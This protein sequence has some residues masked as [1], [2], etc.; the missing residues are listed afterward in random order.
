[1]LINT[2]LNRT[3]KYLD[4]LFFPM[5]I[6]LLACLTWLMPNSLPWI[7][8]VFYALISFLP[9]CGKDG[10]TYIPLLICLPI[11]INKGISFSSVPAYLIMMSSCVFVSMIIFL[12]INKPKFQ[13]G[14]ILYSLLLLLTVFFISFI[15]NSVNTGSINKTAIFYILALFLCASVYI[16]FST[17][18]GKS[19]TLQYFCESAAFLAIGISLEVFVYLCYHGFHIVGSDF[20]LGWSY[21]SQTASTILCLTLPF[22]AMMIANKKPFWGIGELLAIAA[23]IFLSADSGLLCLIIGIIPL[24]LLAFKNYKYYPYLSLASIIFVGV[25]FSVLLATNQRFS[26]RVLTAIQS[27]N[28]SDERAV[29]RSTLFDKAIDYFK[30]N[31]LL[32]PSISVM[33][34]ENGT[35]TF[36]SNT[37]LSTLVAGGSIGLVAFVIFEF[38]VYYFC[39]KKKATEKW[40]FFTFLLFV[41]LIG[42]IDNTIYNIMILLF[43]L[44][45]NSSYQMSDRPE[46]VII[47]ETY[48]QNFN[49]N[50]PIRF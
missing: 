38:T 10:K 41:E 5:T 36:M 32:G 9:L 1:M 11:T 6:A 2:L 37:I 30:N 13:L 12:I 28:L 25:T 42:L 21:T 49:P 26:S 15:Y 31:P 4:S 48:Y 18:L 17:V 19:K 34:E 33:T 16:I 7:S 3:R 24:I 50:K 44:I 35:L 14:N 23:I 29:W 39:F 45:A 43:F 46:D 40:L 27:L 20:T 47:H 8:A 22:F